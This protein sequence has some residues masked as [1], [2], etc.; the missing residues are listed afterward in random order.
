[1]PSRAD[2]TTALHWAVRANDQETTRLLIQAGADVKIADRYG[3][4]PLRLAAENGSASM[5]EICSRQ[6]QIRIRRCRPAK[7]F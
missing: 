5:I 3:I 1:M 2:G 7:P 6:A 4:P